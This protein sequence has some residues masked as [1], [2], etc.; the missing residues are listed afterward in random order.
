MFIPDEERHIIELLWWWTMVNISLITQ[1]YWK[2]IG[3]FSSSTT[4]TRSQFENHVYP[5][6]RRSVIRRCFYLLVYWEFF[7]FVETIMFSFLINGD[8]A[9]ERSFWYASFKTILWL[10][11]IVKHLRLTSGLFRRGLHWIIDGLT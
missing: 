11:S 1:H 3:N 5:S 7:I 2:M 8:S 9:L 4:S 10:F 6:W